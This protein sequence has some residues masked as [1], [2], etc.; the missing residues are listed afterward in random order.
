MTPRGIWPATPSDA[1]PEPLGTPGPKLS[2]S[3]DY[4]FMRTVSEEGDRPV[5]WDPCRPI[6]LV[7]NNAASPPGADALVREAVASVHSETGLQFV[8]DGATTETPAGGRGPLETSRYGDRWSPVLVAWTDPSVVPGLQGDVAGLA[9]PVSAPYFTAS[10]QHWVSGTVKLDGPQFRQ[11]L[12]EADGWSA[13]RA[14]VMHEFAHLVGLNHV[15]VKDQL[16]YEENVGQR[17]FGPGDREGLRQLGL[18]P[19]FNG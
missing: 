14:I 3:T 17:A 10:Q 6:H 7:L 15:P 11:V 8:F 19:C 12:Q 16:M 9:G 18:G 1:R 5:A 4:V 2:S 13:A